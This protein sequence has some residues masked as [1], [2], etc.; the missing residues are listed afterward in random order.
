[1]G[2]EEEERSPIMMVMDLEKEGS[3][4]EEAGSG[5]RT[6]ITGRKEPK[7]KACRNARIDRAREKS[8]S[9][10]TSVAPLAIGWTTAA[11]SD[12]DSNVD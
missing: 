1:M 5:A 11:D 2:D 3:V 12:K 8:G 10:G 4:N 6:R 9:T 7:G